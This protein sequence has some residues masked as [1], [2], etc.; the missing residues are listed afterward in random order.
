MQY[1][2]YVIEPVCHRDINHWLVRVRLERHTNWTI[3]TSSYDSEEVY[4]DKDEADK[5]AIEFGRQIIDGNCPPL[6][7][8]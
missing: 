2:N 5:K 6:T 7:P 3:Y 1:E 4:A 8:P